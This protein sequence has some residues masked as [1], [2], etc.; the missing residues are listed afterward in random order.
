MQTEGCYNQMGQLV[1]A[2]R[3]HWDPY[4]ILREN[5]VAWITNEICWVPPA[6]LDRMRNPV[7]GPLLFF[8]PMGA[9]ISGKEEVENLIN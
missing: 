6:A 5:T 4:S 2:F 1:E 9:T 7:R 3:V 8:T